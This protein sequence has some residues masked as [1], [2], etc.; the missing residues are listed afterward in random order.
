MTVPRL[1]MVLGD[2]AGIGPEIASWL[3]AEAANRA[4]VA[5]LLVA[6]TACACAKRWGCS[7]S[8]VAARSRRRTS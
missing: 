5:V 2:P 1:A 6:W 3:L 8:A 7:S 4:K